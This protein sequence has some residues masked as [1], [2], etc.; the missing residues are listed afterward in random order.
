MLKIL[1]GIMYR[2]SA[3]SY[4]SHDPEI[5]LQN[6]YEHFFTRRVWL[7]SRYIPL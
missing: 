4:G 7:G 1:S 2:H 5:W 6:Q 3:L